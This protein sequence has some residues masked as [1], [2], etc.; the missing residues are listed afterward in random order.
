MYVSGQEHVKARHLP[1]PGLSDQALP[2]QCHMLRGVANLYACSLLTLYTFSIQLNPLS[3]GP[4]SCGTARALRRRPFYSYFP[5]SS[6]GAGSRLDTKHFIY[7]VGNNIPTPRKLC[8]IRTQCHM[9]SQRCSN[10]TD[11]TKASLRLQ[12]VPFTGCRHQDPR[13]RVRLHTLQI[14]RNIKARNTMFPDATCAR[15]KSLVSVSAYKHMNPCHE[16]S[17]CT[18]TTLKPMI[19]YHAI[20]AGPGFINIASSSG[21]QSFVC[22]YL[23][24]HACSRPCE[25]QRHGSGYPLVDRMG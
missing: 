14:L 21:T 15:T 12:R 10:D 4:C 6:E 5:R 8:F 22:N 16:S 3:R 23:S 9:T 1:C 18:L 2:P 13:G 11:E 20:S 7:P 19:G 25:R 17:P 24:V